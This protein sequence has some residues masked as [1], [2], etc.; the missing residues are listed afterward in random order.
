MTGVLDGMHRG[1]KSRH[2]PRLRFKHRVF[3]SNT[4]S[5]INTP[6]LLFT[7]FVFDSHDASSIHTP[8]LR[9]PRRVFDSNTASSIQTTRLRFKHRLFHSHTTS[10][11]RLDSRQRSLLLLRDVCSHWQTFALKC[12]NDINNTHTGC[13][14]IAKAHTFLFA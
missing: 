14:K 1:R 9:F 5:S 13:T 4:A 2:T 8:R 10:L 12:A 7:L 11:S 3:D 6:R